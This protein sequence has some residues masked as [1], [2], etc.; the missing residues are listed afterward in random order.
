MTHQG[1]KLVLRMEE[2]MVFKMLFF[3]VEAF[4]LKWF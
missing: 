3:K 1:P 4:Y 2:N